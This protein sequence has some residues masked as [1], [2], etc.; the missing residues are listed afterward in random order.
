VSQTADEAAPAAPAIRPM[1]ADARRNY[2]ALIAA[3]RE[4]FRDGDAD[5][6][7]EAIAQ[8]AGV[9]I[10][11]LYRHFPNR[12]ALLEAVYRDEVDALGAS[13]AA[14]LDHADP[15]GG[16]ARLLHDFSDYATTKRALFQ[17]LVDAVGRDSDLLTHSRQVIETSFRSVLERAQGAGVVRSDVTAGDVIRL[18]GGCTMMP[19]ATEDQ[20]ARI[21]EVVLAGLRA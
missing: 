19:G 6:S 2:E 8:R 4:S 18:V 13:A 11:T 14:N 3:A 5:T 10:G 12:L 20:Q 7:L 17:E 1:R 15:W 21:L 16:F 9:G